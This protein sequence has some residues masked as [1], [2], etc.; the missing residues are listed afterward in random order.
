MSNNHYL[1]H[2]TGVSN[3]GLTSGCHNQGSSSLTGTPNG[4]CAGTLR[5]A[6]GKN[7]L[8]NGFTNGHNNFEHFEHDEGELSLGEMC[9]A[10]IK[11]SSIDTIAVSF[12]L[13]C[14]CYSFKRL[15]FTNVCILLAISKVFKSYSPNSF[16]TETLVW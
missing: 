2:T 14:L 8:K 13:F 15:K 11:S 6:N 12:F 9:P 10:L 16:S 1:S 5:A 7:G 4:K 3:D